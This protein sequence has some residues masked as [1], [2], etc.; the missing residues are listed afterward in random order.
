MLIIKHTADMEDLQ[1]D[2]QQQAKEQ[3]LKLSNE[4][5]A[6]CKAIWD[7][8]EAYRQSA[9]LGHEELHRRRLDIEEKEAIIAM[10]GQQ[11]ADRDLKDLEAAQQAMSD[12]AMAQS[13]EVA[14]KTQEN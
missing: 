7:E 8:R 5:N 12:P 4:Y 3:L 10:Y 11:L 14:M 13:L 6:R 2:L 9:T 1:K